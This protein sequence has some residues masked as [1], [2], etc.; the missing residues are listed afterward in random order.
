MLVREIVQQVTERRDADF[1][2]QELG[3]VGAYAWQI[4]YGC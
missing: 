3:P 1:R 4:G 2:L